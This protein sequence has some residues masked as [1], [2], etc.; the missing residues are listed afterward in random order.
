MEI[1]TRGNR[2]LRPDAW[3]IFPTI[4]KKIP[5]RVMSDLYE[6]RGEEEEDEIQVQKGS[7]DDGIPL[8][9]A[10]GTS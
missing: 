8:D 9:N 2:R 10:L 7:E 4:Q 6:V 3:S 5:I 1:N